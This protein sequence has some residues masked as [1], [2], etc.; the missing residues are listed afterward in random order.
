MSPCSAATKPTCSYRSCRSRSGRRRGA[1]SG[2][3]SE[4][5][6]SSPAGTFRPRTCCSGAGHL[7]STANSTSSTSST[8]AGVRRG[9]ARLLLAV[10][11]GFIVLVSWVGVGALLL[12]SS[13]DSRQLYLFSHMHSVTTEVQQ[14][15]TW[16]VEIQS[17]SLPLP[18]APGRANVEVVCIHRNTTN[19]AR[20]AIADCVCE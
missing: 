14:C 2:T 19:S 8:T 18:H 17:C 12:H 10:A 5:L 16:Y 4:L 15:A 7:R 20:T 13:G 1:G 9:C 3:R 6:A 11:V